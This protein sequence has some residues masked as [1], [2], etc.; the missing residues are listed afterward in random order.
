MGNGI[1]RTRP[2]SVW[3]AKG[4]KSTTDGDPNVSSLLKTEILI[5][6]RIGKD[7]FIIVLLG[8]SLHRKHLITV[9]SHR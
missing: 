4:E 1:N 6:I 3:E 5:L 9:Q 7:I 2:E 8:L